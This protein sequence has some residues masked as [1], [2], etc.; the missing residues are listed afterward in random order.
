ME[1]LDVFLY[2][3]LLDG[4]PSRTRQTRQMKELEIQGSK[5]LYAPRQRGHEGA[6]GAICCHQWERGHK[7]AIG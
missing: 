6:K 7:G 3:L 2:A 5:R 1:R 4:N